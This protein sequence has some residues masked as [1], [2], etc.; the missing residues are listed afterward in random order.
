[1]Q[2]RIH[3]PPPP[4]YGPS[5]NSLRV[6]DDERRART[7]RDCERAASVLVLVTLLLALI[8]GLGVSAWVLVL[9]VSPI[10]LILAVVMMV[11]GGVG[12]GVLTLFFAL[13]ILPGLVVITPIVSAVAATKF[14][15]AWEA[16]KEHERR[17]ELW[18][19]VA[20][21]ID[22]SGGD[23]E[24]KPMNGSPLIMTI[25]LKGSLAKEASKE[26]MTATINAVKA[27][28]G[29]SS[30]VVLEDEKGRVIQDSVR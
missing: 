27:R 30:Y 12:K 2:T 1:M 11:C 22:T 14:T 19:E 16:R 17:E 13:L 6:L 20:A 7:V 28:L 29:R 15:D 25:V 24:V 21:G 3:R 5:I 18:K 9:V 26:S 8:P 10:L 23:I 4:Q